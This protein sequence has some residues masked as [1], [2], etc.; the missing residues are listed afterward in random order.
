MDEYFKKTD[1]SVLWLL[2]THDTAIKN[3][4]KEAIKRGI[5]PERIIYADKLKYNEHLKRFQHMDL[6]LD[7]FPYNAHTTACEAIRCGV[8]IITLIGET[9]ASRVAASLLNMIGMKNLICS[10]IDEY[11]KT[12]VFYREN[13]NEFKKLKKNF[14]QNKID[15]F[16]NSETYTKN[17]EK[18]YKKLLLK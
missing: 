9:F 10:D 3:L 5:E 18:I 6:F 11:V 15:N 2:N 13:T 17:L 16:F 14:S 12:A 8:P 7:T 4:N 1:N